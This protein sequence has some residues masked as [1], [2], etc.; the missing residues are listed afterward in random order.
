MAWFETGN[1]DFESFRGILTLLLNRDLYNSAEEGIAPPSRMALLGASTP[2]I[3]L[4]CLSHPINRS[5]ATE[6]I[7][8]DVQQKLLPVLI[9]PRRAVGSYYL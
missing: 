2:K 8:A 5:S 3:E 9:A 6:A 4:I 7:S 1:V